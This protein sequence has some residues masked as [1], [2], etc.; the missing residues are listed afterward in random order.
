MLFEHQYKRKLNRPSMN[1]G[2]TGQN[3]DEV[4]IFIFSN[5]FLKE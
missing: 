5:N 2:Y 1:V 4:S 3:M